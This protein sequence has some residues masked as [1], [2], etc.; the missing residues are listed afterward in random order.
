[1]NMKISN[2]KGAVEMSLNLIIMLIIGLVVLGLVIGFVQSLV[3]KGK[4]SF[5]N[6]IGENDQLKLDQVSNCQNNLCLIPSPSIPIKKGDRNKVYFKVRNVKEDSDIDCQP[7]PL[8]TSCGISFSII[9]EGG[10]PV[11]TNAF[12]LS[13][14]GF[15]AMAGGE[16]LSRMYT[17]IVAD[18]SL[19]TGTYYV[20]FGL[21]SDSVDS[22][23]YPIVLTMEVK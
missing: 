4:T 12:V 18:N 3:N 17:I 8:D 7:G 15:P 22:Y 10:D 6:Q 9:D 13:G 2:K 16:E 11:D 14:P 20:T 23:E 1:M 19:P 21:Y 5:E